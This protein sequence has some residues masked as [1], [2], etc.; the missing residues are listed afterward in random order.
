MSVVIH[1][2]P[3][4]FFFVGSFFKTTWV[5]KCSSTKWKGESKDT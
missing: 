3:V 4:I 5:K 2:L 1:L